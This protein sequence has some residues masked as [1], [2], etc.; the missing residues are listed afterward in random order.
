MRHDAN[1]AEVLVFTFKDGL[2]AGMAHDL[3]LRV[4]EFAIDVDEASGAV[5]ATFEP[6]S[7]KVVCAM[8]DGSDDLEALSR[9]DYR[10][11]EHHIALEVLQPARFG[12][13][14]FDGDRV[15]G[16]MASGQALLRGTLHLHGQLHDI[17]V[18]VRR[19]GGDWIAEVRL[20]QR[21]WGIRPFR[22]MMGALKVQPEV[23]V[24]VRLP[25][26]SA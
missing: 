26:R 23:L 4:Q 14:R 22:A 5:Q 17:D 24:Q 16:D 20:D 21:E 6:A 18:P 1:D 25:I 12:E 7:L 10:E 13:L 9:H 19:D 15:E 3:K 8:R 2:L 11:I